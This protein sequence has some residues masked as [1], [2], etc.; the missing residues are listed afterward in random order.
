M[1][2]LSKIFKKKKTFKNLT[3]DDV[4]EAIIKQEQQQEELEKRITSAQAKIDDLMKKGKAEKDNSMKIFYAKQINALKAEKQAALKRCQFL[5][6]NIGLLNRVKDTID[7]NEFFKS[8]SAS[9]LNGLLADQ[10]ALSKWLQQGL[11]TKMNAESSLVTAEKTYDEIES[12]YVA[13]E[14]IYGVRD[15]DDQLLAMFEEGEVGLDDMS[16]DATATPDAVDPDKV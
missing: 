4:V 7:D 3:R 5:L 11:A 16:F 15:N 12:G 14:E 2:V 1:G 13:S 8:T 10:K 9:S 6:Y